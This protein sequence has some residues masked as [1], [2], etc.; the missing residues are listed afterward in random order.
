MRTLTRSP[1]FNAVK[2]SASYAA[3]GA[4][5]GLAMVAGASAANAQTYIGPQ[6]VVTLPAATQVTTH[7]VRTVQPLPGRRQEVTTT[8]T[9]TRRVLPGSTA[10]VAGSVVTSPQPLYDQATPVEDMVT[11]PGYSRPLYDYAGPRYARPAYDYSGSVYS[12]PLYDE[13]ATPP[14]ATTVIDNGSILATQP[15]LYRYVYQPD[16][17]LVIDPATGDAIQSIPR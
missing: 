1:Q 14:A 16:R 7:T 2:F 9:V 5:L 10:V 13:V 8:R 3:V 4:A 15:Y 12:R 17:I 11:T 6:Q